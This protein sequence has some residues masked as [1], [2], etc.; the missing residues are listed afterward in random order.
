MVLDERNPVDKCPRCGEEAYDH[1]GPGGAFEGD[2]IGRIRVCVTE[3][4]AF[5]HSV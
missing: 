4:G 2:P 1:F 3:E 5:F